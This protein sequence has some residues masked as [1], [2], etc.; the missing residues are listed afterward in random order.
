MCAAQC[1]MRLRAFGPTAPHCP[2]ASVRDRDMWHET[3][4]IH[5]TA[6]NSPRGPREVPRP[7][8]GIP[9]ADHEPTREV[10]IGFA[11]IREV[12]RPPRE[13]ST[14]FRDSSHGALYTR[15]LTHRGVN[16]RLHRHAQ[17][18]GDTAVAPSHAISATPEIARSHVAL[19]VWCLAW[20][21]VSQRAGS[22]SQCRLELLVAGREIERD[23]LSEND[24]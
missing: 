17:H 21:L 16:P 8:R 7:A 2:D 5:P 4:G 1:P 15:A 6:R 12:P 19:R 13:P 14:K 11:D 10:P 20:P 22:A 23:P 18:V 24:Y 3:R 9:I